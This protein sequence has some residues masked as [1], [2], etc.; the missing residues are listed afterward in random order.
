M[1]AAEAPGGPAAALQRF[2]VLHEHDDP[3]VE[4]R[5]TVADPQRGDGRGGPAD[6]READE[7]RGVVLGRARGG[8]PGVGQVILAEAKL[9]PQPPEQGLIEEDE[10]GQAGEVPGQASRPSTC[11]HSCAR[12]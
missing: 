2:V 12:T 9:P 7:E 11:D 4:V 6:P 5:A 1:A 10:P 3:P 8:G